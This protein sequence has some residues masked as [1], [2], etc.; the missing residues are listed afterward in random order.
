MFHMFADDLDED[1]EDPD[2]SKRYHLRSE[3]GP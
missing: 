1:I 2:R 3:N